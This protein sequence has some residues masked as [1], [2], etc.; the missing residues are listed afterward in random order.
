LGGVCFKI[1]LRAS[2]GKS[3]PRRAIPFLRQG[4]IQLA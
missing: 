4:K 1:F 3:R 2:F